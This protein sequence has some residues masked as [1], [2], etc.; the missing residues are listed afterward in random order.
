M[1]LHVIELVRLFHFSLLILS[2][3][4]VFNQVSQAV[5]SA[6]GLTR[7]ATS[8]TQPACLLAY[9]SPADHPRKSGLKKYDG[10]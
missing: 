7:S 6:R 3:W 2:L 4:L 5:Y 1:I 8:I 9:S 10:T